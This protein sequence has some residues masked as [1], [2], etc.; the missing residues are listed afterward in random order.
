MDRVLFVCTQNAGRSQ[1][2]SAF[3]RHLVGGQVPVE[4]AGT[5]PTKAVHPVVVEAMREKGIDLLDA[6]PKGITLELVAGADHVVTMGCSLEADG[7]GLLTGSEDWGLDDPAGRSLEEVRRIRDEIEA[8]VF[9]LFWR[10]GGF[11]CPDDDS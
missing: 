5:S 4:S 2:A 6:N 9:S 3:L 11:R 8:R 1:M 7:P 10:L